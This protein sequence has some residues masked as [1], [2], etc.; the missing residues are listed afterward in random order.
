[1]NEDLSNWSKWSQYNY[2]KQTD[3]KR[4]FIATLYSNGKLQNE[5]DINSPQYRRMLRYEQTHS[6]NLLEHDEDAMKAP[7]PNT[8]VP[9]VRSKMLPRRA[10]SDLIKPTRLYI[11]QRCDKVHTDSMPRSHKECRWHVGPLLLNTFGSTC[12]TCKR[13]SYQIGCQFG[14]HVL[15]EINPNQDTQETENEL[16]HSLDDFSATAL[17]QT[18]ISLLRNPSVSPIIDDPVFI[19]QT[20]N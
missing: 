11:C 12:S 2:V 15:L 18:A 10:N 16:E 6:A 3:V 9:K 5:I 4:D 19:T 1:M 14:R 13:P 8:L 7:S 20:Q 17:T